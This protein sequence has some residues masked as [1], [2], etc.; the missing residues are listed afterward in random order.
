MEL[1][2]F[3]A[4]CL[5]LDPNIVVQKY[6][7]DGSS[8]FFDKE[9]ADEFQFKKDI[10]HCLGVHL[11]EVAIVGSGKLGFSIKP[12]KDSPGLY[13]YKEFDQVKKSDL[14]IAIVSNVL[15]DNQLIGLYEHTSSYINN[16][17]W[18]DKADRNSLARYILKG[19]L[20]PEFI[21]NGYKI[22]EKIQEII[23]TYKMKFG[24]DVNIGIYK[25]WYFFESYHLNNIKNIN[26]N[27]I[28]NG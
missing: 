7:L 14:D 22:S 10:S 6:L 19:W 11:R 28:A 12:E 23:S 9:F 20:K 5:S 4:D 2:N 3:K 27:L 13:L 18:N 21:P 15:F 24:R 16:E 1:R 8:Y 17:V 26:L 25:S